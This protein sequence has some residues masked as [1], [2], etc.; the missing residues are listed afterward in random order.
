MTVSPLTV[1]RPSAMTFSA[2]RR[3]ATPARG[4]DLLQPLFHERMIPRAR[5][6]ARAAAA[7]I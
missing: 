1:T 5:A 6:R 2:A 4:E 3:E 7:A